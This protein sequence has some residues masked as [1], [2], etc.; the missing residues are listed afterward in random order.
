YNNFCS[1]FKNGI[2]CYDLFF[3]FTYKFGKNYKFNLIDNNK[4]NLISNY[5]FKFLIALVILESFNLQYY[6]FLFF[7]KYLFGKIQRRSLL[8]EILGI[9]LFYLFSNINNRTKIKKGPS[10]DPNTKGKRILL[11]SKGRSWFL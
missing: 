10:F 3:I 8:L 1:K 2:V 4:F 11:T 6:I 5:K 9:K 7:L